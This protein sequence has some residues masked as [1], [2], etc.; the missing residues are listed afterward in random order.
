MIVKV[1]HAGKKKSGA[2]SFSMKNQQS[3]GDYATA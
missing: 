1:K 3:A 2:S